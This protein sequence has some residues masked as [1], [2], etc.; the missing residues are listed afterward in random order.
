M[1]F[2]RSLDFW[3]RCACLYSCP[4][5]HPFATPAQT[6]MQGWNSKGQLGDG[7][8]TDRNYAV[9]VQGESTMGIGWR[10]PGDITEQDHNSASAAQ[11]VRGHG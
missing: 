8:T 4:A 7:S 1:D 9:M 5:L 2:I 11:H 10:C 3:L 6:M